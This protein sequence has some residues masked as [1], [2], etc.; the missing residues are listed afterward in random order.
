MLSTIGIERVQGIDSLRGVLI[1]IMAIN[2]LNY[3]APPIAYYTYQ[4]FGFVSAAEG[5]VFLSGLIA[6]MVYPRHCIGQKTSILFRRVYRRAGMIYCAHII[7]F[8]TIAVIF[9]SVPYYAEHWSQRLPNFS[10]HTTSEFALG[11]ALLYQPRYFEI[12]PMYLAFFLLLP[13]LI[14]NIVRRRAVWV[15]ACSAL[16]Y[17]AVH[18][19]DMRLGRHLFGQSLTQLGYFNYLAWQLLFVVGVLVGARSSLGDSLDF[20][21]SKWMIG[22][23]IA[24]VLFLFA[25]R[26]KY[27][28]VPI[29]IIAAT[30]RDRL[31]W[32]RL[33]NFLASAH[34]IYLLERSRSEFFGWPFFALLGRYPLG[35]F[36]LHLILAYLAT[37]WLRPRTYCNLSLQVLASGTFV[38]VLYLCARSYHAWKMKGVP[39]LAGRPW[40]Y[41]YSI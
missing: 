24:I 17:A 2:H 39:R 19:F 20:L 12:V 3:F 1:A 32:L 23:S 36:S 29:D 34:V 38:G 14:L 18:M 5:F 16:V 37:P 25:V 26:H 21:N 41:R 15:L 11:L 22:G 30:S 13:L 4:P 28:T 33:L 31:G 40:S 27:V 9:L 7:T 35:V 8:I 6:G 10:T